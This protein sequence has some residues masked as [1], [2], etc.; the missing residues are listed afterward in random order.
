MVRGGKGE[1][2]GMVRGGKVGG[3][4]MVRASKVGGGG[5]EEL[6]RWREGGVMV[7]LRGSTVEGEGW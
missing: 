3:G 7:R 6:V 4:G 1:G 2:G 5:W